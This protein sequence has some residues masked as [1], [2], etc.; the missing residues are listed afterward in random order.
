MSVTNKENLDRIVGHFKKSDIFSHLPD[1]DIDV[2]AHFSAIRDYEKGDMVFE[3]GSKSKHMFIIDRGE[4]AIASTMDMGPRGKIQSAGQ[5]IARF[6]SGEMFGEFEFFEEDNRTAYAF[7]AE[8]TSLLIF[9]DE[10]EDL[11]QIFDEYAHI[12][13]KIY[14]KLISVN[15]GRQRLTHRL[16]SE[17]TGWMEELK[18]QMFFDKLTGVYNRTYLED[19]LS[20]NF[21]FLGPEFSLMVIKPDNFKLINDTF[22]HEA[23]D[24]ALQ[25]ISGKLQEI[26]R[27]RDFAIRYRGNEFI[28]VFPETLIDDAVSLAREHLVSMNTFDIGVAMKKESLLQ[29]FSI[30]V[31]AYPEHE[32]EFLLLVEKAFTKVFEQR[33]LGG[34]GVQVAIA[35]QDE[36]SNFLK[37]VGMFSSLKMS[38]LHLVSQRLELMRCKQG[39]EV[40]R[41]KDEGN[42]LF[43]IKTGSISVRIYVQDGTEKEIALLREGEFFGEMA[44]FENAPR[45][46]TCIAAED[47]ELLRL[48]KE[49]FFSLMKYFPHAAINVMKNMLNK[50]T[51]R[52][53]SSGQF[54]TQMV[55]WGEDASLRAVTDKL[56][57]VFNRRY[58][59]SELEKRF[60]MAQKEGTPLSLVMADMDF[61]REV[62]EGYSHEVG[63]QY[64]VEVAKVFTSTFRKTDITSRY[65][66]DEFTIL[67]PDTDIETAM[68]VT[69]GVRKAVSE[70]DFLKSLEGPDLHL[71]VSL[72][73]SCF[74]ATARTLAEL[75]EQADKAL[76][77][78]KNN[79][80][81]RVEHAP[82][83][84][85]K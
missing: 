3:K 42:E 18:K 71:S 41:A 49:D 67:L 59:E 15:A 9:P 73:V 75:T 54:I 53:N 8:D 76:Y 48:D 72:G 27:P 12:F 20:K 10:G 63:D 1:E 80:R 83:C 78:A 51:D 85:K 25:A 43:I 6:I 69:E 7:A 84:E 66:G 52:L 79:G 82:I 65:G 14:H 38:E 4:V 45:S 68:K 40:F 11:D 13:A 37:T 46:A 36:L 81:N 70:L 47:S 64:I 16:I 50:T 17:K 77:A 34:N 56:T 23:G 30:G 44:I 2:L 57:G 28:V 31:A 74:P 26:I 39:G 24:S 58:L 60:N 35:G 29:T 62:N 33:D 32:K 22:G 19:E 55:K 5:A 21:D 61:F